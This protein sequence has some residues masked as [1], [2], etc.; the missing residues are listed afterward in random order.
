M[1]NDIL[2][3]ENSV[4]TDCDKNTLNVVIPEGVTEIDSFAFYDCTALKS[5]SLPSTL[6]KIGGY[7][8]NSCKSVE[9]ITSASTLFP[10]DEKTQK[11]YDATGKR[12]K[13]ILVASASKLMKKK[14]KIEQVQRASADAV[15][16]SILSEHQ[17]ENVQVRKTEKEQF[18][19]V[20]AVDG[21]VELCLSNAKMSKWMQT[22]P[23]LLDKANANATSKELREYAKANGLPDASRKYIVIRNCCVMM[24]KHTEPIHLA[25][26]DGVTE[27]GENAFFICHALSS[28]SIPDSVTEISWDAFKCCT[29]LESVEFGGTVAQWKHVEGKERNMLCYIPAKVVKCSDGEWQKP[30]VYVENCVVVRCLDKNAKSVVIPEGVTKIGRIAFIHCES[31]ASVM[32]PDGVTEIDIGAFKDCTSLTSVVM[33]AGMTEI[34]VMAFRDCTSLVSVEFGGTIAQWQAIKKGNIWNKGIS[35]TVVKCADGEVKI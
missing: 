10:F 23:E 26:P 3:I 32:I 14:A 6:K 27:I 22:L 1:A 33:P 34:G 29:S 8:F 18:V 16:Q 19:A 35:A 7:A 5:L 28:I 12:K 9:S 20:P 11:L 2:T 13:T 17:V 25:I 21:G 15:L 30:D 31:L 24:T 4:V